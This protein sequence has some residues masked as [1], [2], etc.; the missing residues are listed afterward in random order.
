MTTIDFFK[1]DF[2]ATLFPLKTN[3]FMVENH[4]VEMSTYIKEKI[5]KEDVE[6][7]N[8][9][10]QQRVYA[11]KPRGHL[12]RTVKLD[13][14]AEYFIYDLVY[15][16]R[17][18]FRPEVNIA[19]RSFG[20]KFKD[21]SHVPVHVAYKE[22]KIALTEGESS[23][24]HKIQFDIASYFNSIYHHDLA[25]WF[26]S[27]D[28]VAALDS[29]AFGKYIREINSGRSVDFLPQGIYPCKML[30]NEF[31]KYIDL[32]KFV[33]SSLIV[34]FMDDFTLFD[35]DPSVLQQDFIRIQHL[36]GQNGLNVNPSKTHY[37]KPLGNV[38]ET[39]SDL[40]GSLLDIVHEIKFIPTA[41]GV[42]IIE[43]EEEVESNLSQSQID[44]L[45]ALLKDENLD[46]SDAERILFF[47]RSY[48]DSVLAQ[49]PALLCDFRT[50]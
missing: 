27:H 34:R 3:L 39:L 9:L 40:H 20:Y 11:T 24:K 6:S 17:A 19:R 23:Y 42:Q 16:N 36:L 48:S 46:E 32:S 13:P 28:K 10:S 26:G 7:D 12:R 45:L 31:L 21:G 2:Q 33:K 4:S 8:F 49:I 50:S 1:S 29:N 30:G 37:D 18:I 5:L 44:A 25:H 43:E 22:Y 47:L 35:D 41:S 38:Q 15:R 14:V